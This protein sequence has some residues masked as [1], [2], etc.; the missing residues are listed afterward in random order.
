MTTIDIFRAKSKSQITDKNR[1][2]RSSTN[3][4]GF[5]TDNHFEVWVD[6]KLIFEGNKPSYDYTPEDFHRDTKHKES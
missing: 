4:S 6:D 2:D 5:I 1:G 3:Y